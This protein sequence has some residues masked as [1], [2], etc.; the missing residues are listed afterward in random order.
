MP[1]FGIK[2]DSVLAKLNSSRLLKPQRRRGSSGDDA[3]DQLQAVHWPKEGRSW[4]QMLYVD[5]DEAKTSNDT[6][7]N[8]KER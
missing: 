7:E 2:T 4:L 3:R 8:L 5:E 1:Y 6:N